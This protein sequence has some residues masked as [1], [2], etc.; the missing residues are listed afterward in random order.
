MSIILYPY[1]KGSKGAF[2]LKEALRDLGLRSFIRYAAPKHK[3]SLLVNWG[4][5]AFDY[6]PAGYRVVNHPEVIGYLTNKLRF[7]N[8]LG[9]SDYAP[10]W[11][12]NPMEALEWGDKYLIRHKLEASGGAGIEVCEAGKYDGTTIPRAPLYVRY[13]GKS[14]EY[15]V[16]VARSLNSYDFRPIL[17]QRKIFQKTPDN[18][19][20][21]D[22]N[23]RNHANGFVYVRES[24]E[25]IPEAVT[26]LAVDV[27]T[28]QFREV[29]FAALDVIYSAKK[30]K[31]VV[32]EGN[33]APGLE[34]NT[35][36]AYA[37]YLKGLAHDAR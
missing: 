34:G 19:Q 16:H 26:Q 17:V 6:D 28:R 18:P 9:H 30:K 33:T 20:P 4:N 14:H 36:I 15:R 22:W 5:S 13:F 31:A 8:R 11:T 25:P 37:T 35:V 2:Q 3:G 27:M 12:V 32:L 24:G 10:E 7:F 1:K 23:I 21:K 29:H